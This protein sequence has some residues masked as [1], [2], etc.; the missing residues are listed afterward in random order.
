MSNI[1]EQVRQE[2][3]KNS[4]E[5]TKESGKRF[6]KEEVRFYGVKTMTVSKISKEAFKS[7]KKL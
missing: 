1:I 5:T 4:D 7:I 6:F 3:I 2:L